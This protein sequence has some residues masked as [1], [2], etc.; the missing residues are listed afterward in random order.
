M[1]PKQQNQAQA[2]LQSNS[3]RTSNKSKIVMSHSHEKLKLPPVFSK[4]EDGNCERKH[5]FVQV[6][7]STTRSSCKEEPNVIKSAQNH[8][9]MLLDLDISIF[10]PGRF[11]DLPEFEH[12]FIQFE[13]KHAAYN[14]GV[15]KRMGEKTE[16]TFL[17]EI[18]LGSDLVT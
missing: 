7:P 9:R 15:N 17:V 16:T 6:L 13:P 12:A 11:F 8:L 14:K 3:H 10:D 2:R 5:L 4:W 18:P 1:K